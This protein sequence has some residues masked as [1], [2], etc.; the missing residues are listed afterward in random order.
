M[1]FDNQRTVKKNHVG[2]GNFYTYTS[3]PLQAM[4][5]KSYFIWASLFAPWPPALSGYAMLHPNQLPGRRE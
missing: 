3:D 1:G 4:P 2:G 5:V